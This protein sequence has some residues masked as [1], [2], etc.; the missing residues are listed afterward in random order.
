MHI[1]NFTHPIRH[2]LLVLL[3]TAPLLLSACGAGSAPTTQP[4]AA[5]IKI[6]LIS[7]G[8][9]FDT[10]VASFKASMGDLGYVEGKNLTY[11]YDG[12]TGDPTKL[13]PG[14]QKLVAA[15]VNLIASFGTPATDAAKRATASV[16]IPVIFSP[17]ADPVGSKFVVSLQKPGGNMTGVA[18]GVTV[19]AQRLEMLLKIV[20]TIKHVFAPYDPSDSSAVIIVKALQDAAQKLNVDL[21]VQQVHNPD[22]VTTMI[23]NI[24]DNADAVFVVPSS[25]IGTRFADFIKAAIARKL[26]LSSNVMSQVNQGSLMTYSFGDVELG[27][28]MSAMADQVLKGVKPADLPVQ[29][30]EFFLAINLKTAQAINLTISGDFLRQAK[31]IVR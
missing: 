24:P 12:P 20:P 7:G 10:V 23:S 14:A 1:H 13:G 25:I 15:Q 3:V 17:V 27:K 18:T 22:E 4:T 26:P 8:T 19:H 6:G 11:L 30:S 16:A 21:M 29:T 28:Q 9:Q 31:T 2:T 5:N